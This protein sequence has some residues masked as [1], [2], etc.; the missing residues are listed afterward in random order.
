MK[1]LVDAYKG[2]R[3]L[4]TGATGFKGSWLALWL[5]K[6]G[7][8][9]TAVGLAPD[10]QPNHWALTLPMADLQLVDIRNRED[11]DRCL[12]GSRPEVIFHLAA[13]PLV[14]KSYACPLDTWATNVM[15]TANLLEGC[16]TLPEL[17]AILVITSDKCYENVNVPWG[18]RETDALGGHDPYSASKAACE[19]LTASYRRSFF[20]GDG[21]AL[22]AT[23]R[24][25]NVIGGGDWAEDRLIP[26]VIRSIVTG[27]QLSIRSPNATR[28]WQH[29]LDCLHGYLVLGS[30]L[31]AGEARFAE[32][33][34]FGPYPDSNRT[35]KEVLDSVEANG[36][37]LDWS[38]EPQEQPKESSLLYLDSAK[39]RKELSWKPV[40]D[41]DRTM[42]ETLRWYRTWMSSHEIISR[43]QLDDYIAD[44]S[45]S[46]Y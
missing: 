29:V 22:I 13:Q 3:V 42:V 19:I 44:I 21:S 16:R 11:L 2:R 37:R 1:T 39:V 35:V 12:H 36:L 27:H 38:L 31:V 18:Y 28:P 34:N 40:W 6:L 33:W 26:D 24:A 4:I 25:G 14:R 32:A 15:G 30:R 9:V 10:T 8:R 43:M 41:F 46:G 5:E 45:M 17:K 23:A 20:S 7:A